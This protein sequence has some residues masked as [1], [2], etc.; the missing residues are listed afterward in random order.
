MSRTVYLCAGLGALALFYL[1]W[2][3]GF[4]PGFLLHRRLIRLGA[5]IVGGSGIALSSVLFQTLARNRILTPSIMGYEAIYMLFQAVLILV[6]GTASLRLLGEVGNMLLSILLMLGWSLILHL[7]L[8]RDGRNS[9][10]QM[11]LVGLV[12]TL[13]ITSV[14]QFVQLRISPGEFAVFQSFALISFDGISATRLSIAALAVV[15]AGFVALSRVAIWDVMALGRD[16][17]LSLGLDHTRALRLCLALIAVCVAATTSLIGPSAFMGIFIA[18]I[19]YVLAGSFR[20]RRTLPFGC[21]VAVILFLL[22]ELMVQHLFNYGTTIGILINLICGSYFLFL[23]LR[24]ARG[25]A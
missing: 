10:H 13:I 9:V 3:T 17:A 24:P 18:N 5:M 12:L 15:L 19:A 7:W 25:P 16:Q 8:F 6:L 2:D 4:A 1:G 21:L 20:H 22:T 23:I 14:T 11:L